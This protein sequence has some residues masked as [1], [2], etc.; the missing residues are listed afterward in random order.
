MHTESSFLVCILFECYIPTFHKS[1]L[2][3]SIQDLLSLYSIHSSNIYVCFHH[4]VERSD[5]P[6]NKRIFNFCILIIRADFHWK[7][8]SRCVLNSIELFHF[9][10]YS[11]VLLLPMKLSPGI[12]LQ[13]LTIV[14]CRTER[15]PIKISAIQ[16]HYLNNYYLQLFRELNLNACTFYLRE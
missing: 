13:Q 9:E 7:I 6:S 16:H 14:Y 5:F 10:N 1:K 8:R 11:Q 3:I 15:K 2:W 4:S 12:F